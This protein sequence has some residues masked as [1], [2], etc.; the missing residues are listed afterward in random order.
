[1][2]LLLAKIWTKRQAIGKLTYLVCTG[3]DISYAVLIL[4]RFM[5]EP[6]EMHWRFVKQLLKYIKTTRDYCL[7]YL[8]IGETIITG[9][10]DSDHAGDLGDRKSTSGFVF[11]LSGCAISWK[12]Q[13]QKTVS[14]SSTEA[15]Y[16][17]L[18]Q[19]TQEAIWLKEL[20][21]ELG[22]KQDQILMCGDNISKMHIVKNLN[23][24]NRSKHID[25]RYHFIRDHYQS[26]NLSLQYIESDNLCADFL[27]KG[28]CKV[29]H[30]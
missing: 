6:K 27:T 29:K 25:V 14:I 30:Y 26:G 18:S 11:M 12:S 17:S 16:V 22:F 1:M 2:T 5:S 13:E 9:Y 3:P 15:E 4:S 10:S 21:A 8:R 23:S 7:L 19:A 24:H 28:V 20:M